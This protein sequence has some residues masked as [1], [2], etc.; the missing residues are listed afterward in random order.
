MKSFPM[1]IR[2]SGRRVVIVGGES[3]PRR[4]PA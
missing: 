1:F 2:T 3:R 4:K